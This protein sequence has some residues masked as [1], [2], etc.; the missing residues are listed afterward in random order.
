MVIWQNFYSVIS[1]INVFLAIAVIFIERRNVAV[2]WAWL[3]V[4]LFLPGVGFIIYLMFGQNV[5][6]WKIYKFKAEYHKHLESRIEGQRQKFSES[7]I[8]LQDP[9]IAMYQDMIYMNLTSAHAIFT[10]DNEIATYTEGTDKF[11]ALLED[12]RQAEQH[13]HIMY[14][15]VRNDSTGRMLLDA[16]TEKAK[17][18]VEVRFL[19][20]HIGCTKLP[21]HF[22]DPLIAAGGRT[23]AF[24]PSKIPL[25][26]F[27]LNYRN[28]RKLAIIDGKYGYIGGFNVGDEYVGKNPRFGHWR[29]THLRIQGSAVH[30]M[31]AQFMLD[32][33]ISSPAK[34]VEQ[35]EYF[36]VWPHSGKVG[37]QIVTSGPDTDLEQIK[38]AYIKMILAAKHSVYIQTPYFIPDESLLT[39]LK[40][41]ALSGV[42]VRIMIP[43]K[44]DHKWV[45]WASYSYL[46]D[47][48]KVGVKCLLYQNG[49]LHAKTFVIDDK[50]ASVGTANV[51][52]RSFKLN[53]EV[54]A[55]I[56]DSQIAEE[57]REIFEEDMKYCTELTYKGY[58]ERP[59]ANKLKES[60]ARLLSPIF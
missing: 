6:R 13:I 55:F 32:W 36:P 49:F 60:V 57:L 15:I 41:A 33:N 44:P 35:T 2:T 58:M 3:M 23:A 9:S 17:A 25:L 30:F 16:L 52:I 54:N 48:L 18:G 5:S 50:V 56:Y 42:D 46:S 19:Y 29:D 1:V 24:F 43:G 14:Y 34:L 7:R 20:D 4:L 11:N 21:R 12:I 59:T 31:Q 47:V 26:N 39:A 8:T 45:Y 51:D 37:V 28:H 22:F 40:M 27:K 38:N 10:Q 53:F